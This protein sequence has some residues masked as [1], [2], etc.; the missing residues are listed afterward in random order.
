MPTGPQPYPHDQRMSR[1]R[2]IAAKFQAHYGEQ[3]LASG[4]YGSVARSA[5]GPHSD[6]EIHVVIDGNNIERCFEWSEGPWKAEVDVYSPDVILAQAAELDEFWPLTHGAYVYVQPIHD[7]QDIFAHVRKVALAH[8]DQEIN[9]MLR[10]VLIGDIYECIGKLRNGILPGFSHIMPAYAVD[11]VRFGACLLG[12]AH[13]RIYSSS[14]AMF[15]ESLQ[16]P[17][18]PTGYNHLCGMVMRGELSNPPRLLEAA[19]AYWDGLETWAAARGLTIHTNLDTL[20][21]QSP[22]E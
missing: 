22:R 15:P 10:E 9:A 6:I 8:T 3:M 12:L 5:D 1:A 18:R 2:E 20:L 4:L 11:T 7:P 13:R 21:S 14:V 16:L 19:N 17:D